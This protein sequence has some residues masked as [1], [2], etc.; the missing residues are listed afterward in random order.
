MLMFAASK[1]PPEALQ[2]SPDCGLGSSGGPRVGAP[3]RA[4][5]GNATRSGQQTF[6]I[7]PRGNMRG[8]LAGKRSRGNKGPPADDDDDVKL[9]VGP[10]LYFS[11]PM[12]ISNRDKRVKES[13]VSSQGT[14]ASYPCG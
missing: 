11:A 13:K 1:T 8:M 14:P 2:P 4:S 7:Q 6:D 3:A 9:W 12:D 5:G 10:V